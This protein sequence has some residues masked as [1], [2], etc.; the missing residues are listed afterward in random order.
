[1]HFLNFYAFHQ[2]LFC[3]VWYPYAQVSAGYQA[4]L[5]IFLQV[6]EQIFAG[7]R[8]PLTNFRWKSDPSEWFLRG[9]ISI[10]QFPV[11]SLYKM[12][13]LPDTLPNFSKTYCGLL[14]PLKESSG[15]YQIAVNKFP[16]G[17]IFWYSADPTEQLSLLNNSLS[18]NQ[19]KSNQIFI[20]PAAIILFEAYVYKKENRHHYTNISNTRHRFL[21]QFFLGGSCCWSGRPG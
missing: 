18:S 17:L 9:L 13:A 14:G 20:S 16:R 2:R 15:G 21:P 19:I 11:G 3:M 10:C 12:S 5:N 4:P 6:S 1:M 8:S 7:Y